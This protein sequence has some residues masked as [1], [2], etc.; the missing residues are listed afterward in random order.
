MNKIKNL[1]KASPIAMVVV[2]LVIAGAASAAL[3]SYISNAPTATVNVSS[4]V[5]IGIYE[6]A[7]DM[8]NSGAASINLTA[9]Y[10]GSTSESFTTIAKNNANNRIGAYY[11]MVI[12]ATDDGDLMTG[13]EFIKMIWTETPW[14]DL[15]NDLDESGSDIINELCVVNSDGILTA[16]TEVTN[17]NKQRIILFWDSDGNSSN[18]YCYGAPDGTTQSACTESEME[19][20][21]ESTG[22]CSDLTP[23]LETAL[24]QTETRSVTHLNEKDVKSL[25]PRSWTFTPTWNTGA[26]GTFTISA[27]YVNTDKLAEYAAGIYDGTIT[28]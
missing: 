9:T 6:G 2:G 26:D 27:Q 11:V 1:F 23:Y 15:R 19:W 20:R 21:V 10:G 16:L 5:D 13:D 12:E 18:E 22:M 4:P 7:Y 8:G 14:V 17:W 25:N 3:V 28:Q 24:G